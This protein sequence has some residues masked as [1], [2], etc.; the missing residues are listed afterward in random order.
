MINIK[1]VNIWYPGIISRTIFDIF[2]F[3][4]IW[5]LNNL[6]FTYIS[7]NSQKNAFTPK[8]INIL[9]KYLLH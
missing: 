9:R 3:D 2:G 8:N 6:R 1:I 5:I 4:I 7:E